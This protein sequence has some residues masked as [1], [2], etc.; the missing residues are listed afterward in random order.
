MSYIG[1]N[2]ASVNETRQILANIELSDWFKTALLSA[3]D[4]EPV[5][6]AMDAE[7]LSM[8]L[9]HRALAI[10]AEMLAFKVIAEAQGK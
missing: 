10:S 8:V 2:M 7:L 6:A 5:E 9:E 1:T 3:L 4:R